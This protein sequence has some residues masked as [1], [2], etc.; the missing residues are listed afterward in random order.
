MT[1]RRGAAVAVAIVALLAGMWLGGHSDSL[2]GPL[3]DLFAEEEQDPTSQA[4]DVIEENYF[5]QVDPD[6]LG[7]STVRAMIRQ[8]R[9]RYDDRFSHYFDPKAYHDFREVTGGEFSGVGLSVSEVKRGLR[10]S[11]VFK[12][13]PAAKAEIEEGDIVTAVNGKPIAGE[14]AEVVTGRIKGPEGTDVTLTVLTPSTGKRRELTLTRANVKVPVVAGRLIHA[15]G[16]PVAYVRM[17]TFSDG[18][19]GELRDEIERLD[20]KGA[21][22]LI[23]DLRGNGGGLLTEAI[24]S[25]S[26]FVE[27]G[28]IASTEGRTQGRR[29]YE[30]VGDAL[31]E[32]PTVVLVN[33]DTASAAE[34]LTAALSEADLATVVGET[35]FGKGTFQQVIPL[36]SGGALDLTVGEYLTRN[37]ESLD[38]K[39]YKPDVSATDDEKT[40]PDEALRRA[41]A[42]LGRELSE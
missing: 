20:E 9:R 17:I 16:K 39:G 15:G 10:V 21:E 33:G 4:S 38:K 13:S 40:K 31:S 34:I 19:H 35:T 14:D 8:L 23:L 24:L 2:P 37:G 18:V 7:Q 12:D 27:D 26:V 36:D 29:A 5:H 42:V 22:G 1:G 25:A 11:Q 6:Q 41:R 30:A 28:P 32:R 3:R